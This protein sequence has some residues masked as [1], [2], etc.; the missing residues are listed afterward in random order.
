M[1]QQ[2]WQQCMGN[3]ATAG[4]SFA[5]RPPAA[6][7]AHMPTAQFG[8]LLPQQQQ[9]PPQPLP[10]LQWGNLLQLPFTLP[11]SQQAPLTGGAPFLHVP[12]CVQ[13]TRQA[14]GF[15]ATGP[16]IIPGTTAIRTPRPSELGALLAAPHSI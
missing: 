6:S 7:L 14:G 11:P 12:P 8:T 13:P 4:S 16:T 5:T 2:C 1:L 15:P 9:P 10:G 3:D